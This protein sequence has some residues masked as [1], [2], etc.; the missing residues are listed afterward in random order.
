MKTKIRAT[1]VA[2]GLLAIMSA[3]THVAIAGAVA[4]PGDPTATECALIAQ[5]A[6]AKGIPF[7]TELAN[8][9]GGLCPTP[10]TTTTTAAKVLGNSVVPA[11]GLPKTGSDSSG[12]V[13]MAAAAVVFGA[14]IL[15]VNRR[16]REVEVVRS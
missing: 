10:S 6:A 3:G 14:G 16:R 11:S 9:G 4:I 8:Q 15:I 2:G 1:L 7:A 13:T 12:V 5:Q